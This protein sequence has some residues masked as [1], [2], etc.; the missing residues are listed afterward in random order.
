LVDETDLETHRQY[1]QTILTNTK[2]VQAQVHAQK[3][4]TAL[5]VT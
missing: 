1:F 4:Q 3:S 5:V 2:E